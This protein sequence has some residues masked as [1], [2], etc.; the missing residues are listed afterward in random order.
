MQDVSYLLPKK[1]KKSHKDITLTHSYTYYTIFFNHRSS[2]RERES[3]IDIP[4]AL[5]VSNPAVSKI[6]GQIIIYSLS[7]FL[8]DV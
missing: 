6:A 2:T 3:L 8:V 5:V 7:M 1:K 4:Q